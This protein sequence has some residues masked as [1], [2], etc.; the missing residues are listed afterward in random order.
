M[1][2]EPKLTPEERER[3]RKYNKTHYKKITSDPELKAQFM[4]T[5]VE[6]N[7]KYKSNMTEEQKQRD[8]EYQR[9][10]QKRR[11]AMLKQFQSKVSC[12]QAE[13]FDYNPSK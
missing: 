11:R 5:Q 1:G 7:A 2:T 12:E 3:Q 9:N 10:Y 4:K 6:A 8:R 13:M